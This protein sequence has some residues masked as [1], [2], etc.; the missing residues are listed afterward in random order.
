MGAAL[1]PSTVEALTIFIAA[2]SVAITVLAT[3]ADVTVIPIMGA[4]MGTPTTMGGIMATPG[5]ED[6]I[7]ALAS[8]RSGDLGA[9]PT[10]MDI[11]PR[12]T[13]IT[14]VVLTPVMPAIATIGTILPILR[15][16]IVTLVTRTQRIATV[17]TTATRTRATPMTSSGQRHRQA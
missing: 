4:I 2:D 14:R 1:T 7:S 8:A 13:R 6:L 3:K 16:T 5:M 15:I 9:T 12:R 17:V 10:A 11:I